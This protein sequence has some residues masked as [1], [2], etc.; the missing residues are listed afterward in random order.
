MVRVLAG[1]LSERINVPYLAS[2]TIYPVK[3][4][5]G[6]TVPQAKILESGAIEHDRQFAIADGEGI[7]V[8]GKRTPLIQQIRSRFDFAQRVIHLAARGEESSFHVDGERIALEAWLSDY[9]GF[10]ARWM[11]QT[12]TGFPDDLESPG[13]TVVGTS[14]LQSVASWFPGLEI[15]QARLRFRANLEIADAEA[16]FEDRLYGKD[17][18]SIPFRIGDVTLQGINPCQRCIVP[19]RDPISGQVWHGFSKKFSVRREE[20]LPAWAERSRFNHF[21]RFA[22]NTRIATS[23]QGKSLHVGDPVFVL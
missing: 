11:E 20:T 15:H 10:P 2:I 4:L 9:F 3:S 17:G 23:E 13:P 18:E 8:N 14:T 21:Y 5:D 1:A 16:F 6:I 12:T 19:T 7:F 22:V